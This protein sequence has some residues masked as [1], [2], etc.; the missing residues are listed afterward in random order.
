MPVHNRIILSL[1][2][3]FIGNMEKMEKFLTGR[4]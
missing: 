4:S 2:S 1:T 3:M